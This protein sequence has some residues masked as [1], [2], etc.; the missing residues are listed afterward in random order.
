MTRLGLL[1][2]SMIA[3][4]ACA[5]QPGPDMTHHAHHAAGH[6]HPA[7][8]PMHKKMQEQAALTD[9]SLMSREAIDHDHMHRKMIEEMSR[10]TLTPPP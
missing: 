10:S 1:A 3:L 4:S 7:N 5:T 8:C 2:A 9:F 6:V